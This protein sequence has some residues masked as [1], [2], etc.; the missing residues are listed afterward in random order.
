[1]SPDPDLR[2]APLPAPCAAHEALSA[3]AGGAKIF[4]IGLSKTGTTSLAS[5]LGMLGYRVKDNMGVTRYATGELSSVDLS[6]VDAH[7]ALTDTPIPSFFRELDTRYPGSKFI[8]T[9][10]DSDGWLRSCKKQ[11]SAAHAAKQNDAHARLFTDLYD[12]TVFDADRFARGYERFVRGVMT[13]F[14]HR[15]QDL[16]VLDVA[17]GEGWE[18]LCPFV[19]RPAPDQPFPK[20][21][22]TQIRWINILDLVAIAEDAGRDLLDA[23]SHDM[24]GATSRASSQ[25]A[26]AMMWST[27]AVALHCDHGQRVARAQRAAYR[28][29][30]SR[31]AHLTPRVPVLSPAS[32]VAPYEQRKG[33]NHLWLVG[34][35]AG[36][37]ANAPSAP[38]PT[39]SIALVEDGKPIYGVVHTPVDG[40]VYYTKAGDGGF[41]IERGADPRPLDAPTA[42]PASAST[43][44]G[45]ALALRLLAAGRVMP[46]AVCEATSEWETAAAHAILR[47]AGIALIDDRLGCELSYNKE[48]MSNG[49][50]TVRSPS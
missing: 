17:A 1:M 11:F 44:P 23:W 6:V 22:V 43:T 45:G 40:A 41:R 15:P 31:L 19:G 28:T 8:L 7:D 35:F 27:F 12:C 33:W 47:S 3:T 46:Y 38:P 49:P 32:S 21:N 24:H 14:T 42:G 36:S 29:I 48:S 25:D 30:A 18:K 13:H 2:S 26:L 20:A 4:G 5:A 10:R 50:F 37:G 9:V 34:P 16:L 39:V